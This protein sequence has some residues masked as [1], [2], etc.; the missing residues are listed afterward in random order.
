[1]ADDIDVQRIFAGYGT[2]YDKHRRIRRR[3]SLFP[4]VGGNESGT[5]TIPIDEPSGSDGAADDLDTVTI[6]YDGGIDGEPTFGNQGNGKR[7]GGTT[8]DFAKILISIGAAQACHKYTM[9]YNPDFSA[10]SQ[11]G[12][13]AMVGFGFKQ[14]NRYHLTGAKGD[15][16]TGLN[17]NKAYGNNFNNLKATTEVN[18]GAVTHG[19]QAGPNW[20]QIEIAEDGTTYTLRTSSDGSTWADEFTDSL[21][22]PLDASTDAGD[23]GIALYLD[24]ADIGAFTVDVTLW[25]QVDCA[26]EGEPGGD[27]ELAFDL[28][29]P[30]NI[31]YPF[32]NTQVSGTANS[33]FAFY[34][35]FT[36]DG[37]D[38]RYVFGL[39]SSQAVHVYMNSGQLLISNNFDA[40]LEGSSTGLAA[41][42]YRVFVNYNGTTVKAWLKPHG[43]SRTLE[44]NTALN[45][46]SGPSNFVRIGG[47]EG[48]FGG[49]HYPLLG[50]VYHVAYWADVITESEG[51]DLIDG[52]IA[53]SGVTATPRWHPDPNDSGR[54]Q[55]S[56]VLTVKNLNQTRELVAP[57]NAGNFRV[58]RDP[59]TGIPAQYN[60]GGG[61]KYWAA[62]NLTGS[63]S[64]RLATSD[65]LETW[66]DHAN[67]FSGEGLSLRPSDFLYLGNIAG[68]H[69]PFLLLTCS[70]ISSESMIH[71][72]TSSDMSSWTF[73]TINAANAIFRDTS[74]TAGGAEDFTVCRHDGSWIA[75]Y[76]QET[77]QDGT[78][79]I[80]IAES[81]NTLPS[82][83][84]AVVNN[85][86]FTTPDLGFNSS[87]RFVANPACISRDGVFWLFYE[88]YDTDSSTGTLPL[89]LLRKTA[90]PKSQSGWEEHGIVFHTPGRRCFPDSATWEGSKITVYM[91]HGYNALSSTPSRV[92]KVEYDT[93]YLL[94]DETKDNLT[95]LLASWDGANN[96]TAADDDSIYNH[97]LTFGGGAK[98][99]TSQSVFGGSSLRLASGDY[100]ELPASPYL[101]FHGNPLTI[102]GRVRFNALP[103]SGQ[104]CPLL[105]QWGSSASTRV[106][107]FQ[108]NGDGNMY[109]TAY[110]NGTG[111]AVLTAAWAALLSVDTWYHVAVQRKASAWTMFVDGV[112]VATNT[113]AGALDNKPM[114]IR[115]GTMSAGGNQDVWLDEW[116]IT[117]GKALYDPAGFTPPASAFPKP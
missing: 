30:G 4:W 72:R 97:P 117:S 40:A 44:I 89:T 22:T 101:T 56:T 69:D 2:A 46:T 76:E 61:A 9:T 11:Q 42:R 54:D 63:A 47:L 73:P 78:V 64:C 6:I 98:L 7:I 23:F 91:E 107:L 43:G 25:E 35:D 38:D 14:N 83:G 80:G 100:V 66:A 39:Q 17:A 93:S 111:G 53:I 5:F 95:A 99:D 110:L 48:A 1:M 103:T 57:S 18:G 36:Y 108:V 20:L 104:F 37:G 15:G 106:F 81:T 24:G 96:A 55:T 70:T 31:L 26:G 114:E 67:L 82:S 33:G 41:G 34:A 29:F 115:F 10:L 79:A 116:R 52:N 50:K 90:T 21:P 3:L 77:L 102:E 84:W 45:F 51:L 105:S 85:R 8:T 59:E 113:N 13:L 19:T 65:D 86:A 32:L 109:F 27:G 16:D 88:G 92:G 68:A 75:S 71:A 94:N 62:Y 49:A 58:L 87:S 60:A 74:L 28:T 112:P 12:K